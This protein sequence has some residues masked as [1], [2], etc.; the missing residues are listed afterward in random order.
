[1]ALGDKSRDAGSDFTQLDSF[2][3]SVRGAKE[4]QAGC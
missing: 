4:N 2:G 3:S 1:M